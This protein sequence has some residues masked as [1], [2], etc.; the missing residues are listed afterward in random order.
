[1]F[2]FEKKGEPGFSGLKDD[3]DFKRLPGFAAYACPLNKIFL[4]LPM[5]RTEKMEVKKFGG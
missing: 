2:H 1:M 5:A 3:R 4:M